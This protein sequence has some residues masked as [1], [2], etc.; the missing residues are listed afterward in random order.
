MVI[1]TSSAITKEW[2]DLPSSVHNSLNASFFELPCRDALV[3]PPTF[4]RTPRMRRTS[5][6]SVCVLASLTL[7]DDACAHPL[8]FQAKKHFLFDPI[9]MFIYKTRTLLLDT[10]FFFVLP[11]L[12]WLHTSAGREATLLNRALFPHPFSCAWTDSKKSSKQTMARSIA[13][14]FVTGWRSAIKWL[15]FQ[16]SF[17]KIATY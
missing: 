5:A 11:V 2:P 14:C 7:G 16:V 12:C 6:Q 9:S 3:A 1:V 10:V 15:G 8:T 13:Y 17:R 4:A